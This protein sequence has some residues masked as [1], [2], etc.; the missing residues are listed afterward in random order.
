MSFDRNNFTSQRF[1]QSNTPNEYAY[2]TTDAIATVLAANYFNEMYD[3]LKVKDL[4]KVDASDA[5][6]FIQVSANADKVVT[7]VDGTDLV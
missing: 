5:T 2:V 4:I 3:V 6:T 1:N 7:V